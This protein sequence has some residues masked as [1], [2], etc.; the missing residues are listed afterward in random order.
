[1]DINRIYRIDI[2]RFLYIEVLYDGTGLYL[3]SPG[4]CPKEAVSIINLKKVAIIKINNKPM[5]TVNLPTKEITTVYEPIST[6][7][8]RNFSELSK[9]EHDNNDFLFNQL[10]FDKYL[11]EKIHTRTE[12]H[13]HFMEVLSGEEYLNLI[14]KYVDEIG[15]DS[16]NHL[17][18]AYP[19]KGKELD[20]TGV[21]RI[22]SKEEI[23]SDSNLYNYIV[24]E[25]SIEADKQ[26]PFSEINKI[27]TRRTALLTLAAYNKSKDTLY[28]VL[29][30][31]SEEKVKTILSNAKADIYEEILTKSLE[32]LKEQGIKYV[33]FSFSTQNVF[34]KLFK[35][36]KNPVKGIEFNF[37]LSENRNAKGKAFKDIGKDNGYL[38]QLIRKGYIT[39]FDL[40]G[41][42]QEILERDYEKN[43]IDKSTLYDKLEPI[44]VKLNKYNKDNLVLR[45]HAGEIFYDEPMNLDRK[46]NPERSL[47]II[48][49]I[50]KENNLNIPPPQIR[51]GHGVHI[52]K[53]NNYLKLLKKYKVVVEINASSNFALGNITR[54]SEIPY[55]WYLN[56]GIPVVLGT[57]G[58]GFYLTTPQDESTIA[59]LF[60]GLAEAKKIE[61]YDFD[62]IR[63]RLL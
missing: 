2:N 30:E 49:K 53:N 35:R 46:S 59:Q 45:L 54:F 18:R 14:L 42:E 55:N 62:E 12:L 19:V 32:S 6:A 52:V 16:E 28:L 40:M 9:D 43:S 37:L 44:L 11:S 61:K 47:E 31:T 20:T 25:L 36:F 63:R 4:N 3:M 7:E 51:I 27:L 29:D 58:G 56:N 34:E 17:C 24:K 13:T 21:S 15:F 1:M 48:D 41:M 10:I 38:D 57:D 39:G 60:A 26:V 23:L 33:E 8:I 5:F 22:V 50:A